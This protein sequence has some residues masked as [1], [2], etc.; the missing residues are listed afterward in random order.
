VT[1]IAR[2]SIPQL[3][4]AVAGL[5]GFAA[6]EE[7]ALLAELTTGETGSAANWAAAPLVAHNTEF[8]QQQVQRLAAVAAAQVP[9]EFG[10]IE[11]GSPD[12]YRGYAGLPAAAVAAAS[13]QVTGALLSGLR[14]VPDDDLVDP[15]R[16]E[17]LKGRQLWL[18]IIVRGFWHPCGHLGDYYLGHGQ[19]DRAVDLADRAVGT[20]AGLGA[21]DPARGMA[22]YNLAC[23]Q[24]RAGRPDDAVAAL[25]EAVSRNPDVRA[26]AGRDPDLALL[27]D[28]GQLTDLLNP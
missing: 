22:S 26:N 17:W 25:A 16:I 12:A 9:P 11:H 7:Q 27:R 18:Q 23:A 4:A 24:A 5:L 2:D 28:T 13:W 8:R 19:P 15:A 10:E 1:H 6:A 14:A 20:A 21:P 3:R